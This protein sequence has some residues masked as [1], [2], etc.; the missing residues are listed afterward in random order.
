MLA[1]RKTFKISPPARGTES[2][3]LS[4]ALNAFKELGNLLSQRDFPLFFLTAQ[5]HAAELEH[6]HKHAQC[7]P[8]N[9][10]KLTQSLRISFCSIKNSTHTLRHDSDA[11]FFFA[12]CDSL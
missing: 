4:L 10:L 1:I 11:I 7:I 8:N 9:L 12:F 3:F 6:S 2:I 5:N